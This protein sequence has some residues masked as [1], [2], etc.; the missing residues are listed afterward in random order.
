MIKLKI[1]KMHLLHLI[2]EKTKIILYLHP[3][4]VVFVPN[5]NEPKINNNKLLLLY[6][7]KFL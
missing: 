5:R 1:Y 4:F 6:I 2:I 7:K 3:Y